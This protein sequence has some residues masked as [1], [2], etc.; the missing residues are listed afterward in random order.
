M[1]NNG[2]LK[3]IHAF[4]LMIFGFTAC[5]SQAQDLWKE[6]LEDMLSGRKGMVNFSFSYIEEHPMEWT[7]QFFFSG[8]NRLAHIIQKRLKP[9]CQAHWNKDCWESE[10]KDCTLSNAD[11]R[12][13]IEILLNSGLSQSTGN[14][15]LAPGTEGVSVKYT[16]PDMDPVA[17]SADY[18]EFSSHP[19]WSPLRN[20][21]LKLAKPMQ[22]TTGDILR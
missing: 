14:Q 8:K 3:K 1:F 15:I 4:L 10:D 22:Q 17:F 11:I 13:M 19:Q 6:K 16:V 12:L 21:I 9:G 7:L 20:L 18:L 5:Q 2:N